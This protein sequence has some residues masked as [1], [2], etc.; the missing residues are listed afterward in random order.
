VKIDDQDERPIKPGFRFS[1]TINGDKVTISFE[2]E[3]NFFVLYKSMMPPVALDVV[4]LDAEY[5]QIIPGS[6]AV[7]E[8]PS[9]TASGQ[10]ETIIGHVVAAKTVSQADY[11]ISG[12]AT[13]LTLDVPWLDE[14]DLDLSVLRA[15]TIYAQSEALKRAEEPIKDDVAGDTIEL[16]AMYPGLEA[17]R[18]VIVS[19]ERT[20]IPS[21]SGVEA[22]ELVM[23]ASVI[24]D[25]QSIESDDQETENLPEQVQQEETDDGQSTALPGDKVHT[26]LKLANE[27]LA[28]TYK[29]DTVTIYGNV[30]KATHGETR[31]EVLGSGDGSKARQQF[32]LKQ[33]PLTYLAAATPAG[34]AS[35]LAVRVNDVLWHEADDMFVLEPNDRAYVTRIDNESKTT[36]TF[37]DGQH[38]AR[39]PTGAENVK[40][41][42]RSGIGKMGNVAAGKI[43]LLATRPLGVKG[44]VNPLRA[45]GGADRESRGQ[46]R[47][48]A[49]LAVI[50]LDRLVSVSDYANFARTYAGIAKA[51]AARLSDGRRQVIYLTIAGVGDIPIDETSDLY[52]NLQQALRTCGDPFLPI[53]I[54]MRELMLLVINARVSVLSDYKWKLVAPKIKTAL[55]KTFGFERRKLGQDVLCS[56]VISTIQSVSGV[57]YVDLDVLDSI[58]ESEAKDGEKLKKKLAELAGTNETPQTGDGK[59]PKQRITVKM[60]GEKDDQGIIKQAQ[61]AILSPKVPSTLNLEEIV[62]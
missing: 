25:V 4:A 9:R 37:G 14:T 18:W 52:Q 49:P 50:A 21:T 42:Y 13:Q 33:S 20:D 12:K 60:V 31:Q 23:L 53:Q 1:Y 16:D 57:A 27:G 43:S 26:I 38:G 41:V 55:L 10:R 3:H 46:A 36:V 45:S 54:K 7:I 22:R 17:G 28:Y 40:A 29:R 2:D 62:Q 32:S 44:V 58:S 5:D 8:R 6:W 47:R 19:G 39:L 51:A 61:L 30:V 48:N 56:E 11:G 15:T 35:T 34:A 59:P 24:N